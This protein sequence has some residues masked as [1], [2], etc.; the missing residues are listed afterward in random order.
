MFD[1]N[2]KEFIVM[3]SRHLAY[4]AA[5]VA[6]EA[7]VRANANSSTAKISWQL[8][9]QIRAALDAAGFDWRGAATE[10]KRLERES[11]RQQLEARYGRQERDESS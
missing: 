11:K 1:T 2:K 3:N 7:P 10:H 4:L 9:D 8:V 6:V 5:L